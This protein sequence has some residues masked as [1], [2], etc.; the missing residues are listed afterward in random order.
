MESILNVA[1]YII[2]KYKGKID[3]MKLHKLLYFIQRESLAVRGLPLFYEGFKAWKYGPVSLKVRMFLN[4]K[5]DFLV[6]DIDI[7]NKYIVDNVLMQYGNMN[8]WEMSILT[9]KEKSWL[10]AQGGKTIQFS[11]LE[12]DAYKIRPYDSF[13]DMYYD[14]FEDYDR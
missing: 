9:H 13:W 6:E 11:N 5:F 1:S 4:N 14:E 3:E 8:S 7:N 12:E 10:E 2:G